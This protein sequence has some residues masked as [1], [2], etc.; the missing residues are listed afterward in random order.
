M[1]RPSNMSV[2]HETGDRS[3][4][5]VNYIAKRLRL[6]GHQFAELGEQ[7][8]ESVFS[9][10]YSMAVGFANLHPDYKVSYVRYDLQ[11]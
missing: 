10:Y 4:V 9:Q 8:P 11:K 7:L 2:I 5:E 1:E 6:L 3:F